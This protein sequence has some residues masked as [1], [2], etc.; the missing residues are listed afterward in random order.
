MAGRSSAARR[1][2]WRIESGIKLLDL[3]LVP[4]P[5]GCSSRGA[6]ALDLDRQRGRY[7]CESLDG[8]APRPSVR[9]PTLIIQRLPQRS[10][11]SDLVQAKDGAASTGAE[12]KHVIAHAEASRRPQ[13]PQILLVES[14]PPVR[15]R[16]VGC[17]DARREDW[18]VAW[19]DGH[20]SI[21]G[22]RNGRAQAC[23]H[24]SLEVSTEAA[25]VSA[26]LAPAPRRDP[27]KRSL[28]HGRRIPPVA[29]AG[30]GRPPGY[31]RLYSLY[32]RP[33]Q[34]LRKWNV[35]DRIREQIQQY[36]DQLLG[37]ADKLRKAL[38]ALDPRSPATPA[39][40]APAG[41]RTAAPTRKPPAPATEAAPARRTRQP[42]ARPT[43]RATS[44]STKSAVLQALADGQAMTASE[45]ATKADLGR[46]TVSTTLS[47]LAKSGEVQ[48]AQRGYR[49]AP[50]ASPA[51]SSPA[52]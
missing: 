13:E 33:P 12:G 7:G 39:P 14:R 25:S 47:K 35:I 19:S 8:D 30:T 51:P 38:A 43:G 15:Y 37:E 1:D 42:A 23:Y 27:A 36:L 29:K 34:P 40:K 17:P 20:M 6:H 50:T 3:A 24:S 9:V 5:V 45:V 49:L 18:F 31:E 4:N 52:K 21:F 16:V 22:D 32:D 11:P 48:K 2:L 46:A 26:S 44:G 28:G 41:K 10:A